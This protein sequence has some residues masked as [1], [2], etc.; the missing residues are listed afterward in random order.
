[1]SSKSDNANDRAIDENSSTS[2]NEAG[3]GKDM[4][5]PSI[6]DNNSC[7]ESTDDATSI[8]SEGLF[9][10]EVYYTPST[11]TPQALSPSDPWITESEL[12]SLVVA[13]GQESA[14][15]RELIGQV[16][17]EHEVHAY[18]HEET[19]DACNNNVYQLIWMKM[20][21]P[22]NQE[23]LSLST[24]IRYASK[25]NRGT[26]ILGIADIQPDVDLRLHGIDEVLVGPLSKTIVRQKYMKWT[27]VQT[28]HVDDPN[29][30]TPECPK[31][32][33]TPSSACSD[34]VTSNLNAS[35]DLNLSTSPEPRVTAQSSSGSEM[36]SNLPSVTTNA[37][38]TSKHGS[39]G[40]PSTVL[41]S[42]RNFNLQSVTYQPRPA[43]PTMASS[44]D[45]T[46]KEK[47]RRER[48]KDSCD[49]LRV[50][51]P[52]IRGRKTDMASI[53]EMTVDYLKIVNAAIPADFQNQVITLMSKGAVLPK[54]KTDG[55][56]GSARRS[57]RREP[58]P[59]ESPSTT[60]VSS[61]MD[62][63]GRSE[64]SNMASGSSM[65]DMGIPHSH[66]PMSTPTRATQAQMTMA[67]GK[68]ESTDSFKD[69][70]SGSKRMHISPLP[71]T[72]P[73]TTQSSQG[74]IYMQS[75]T[76]GRTDAND[77]N[78]DTSSPLHLQGVHIQSHI[79]GDLD[80]NANRMYPNTFL[81]PDY[82]I[83][84]P[85]GN[86]AAR[87]SNL[88]RDAYGMYVENA[89]YQYYGQPTSTA[90]Y[91][92]NSLSDYVNPNAV[93]PVGPQRY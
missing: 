65:F 4:R 89:F 2:T 30:L 50:L 93:L 91:N 12:K 9:L 68:R 25:S 8:C 15:L 77:P 64:G 17:L 37:T 46:T 43:R 3:D 84:T 34:T 59:P 69:I 42:L 32:P 54:I 31:T 45:H 36:S 6:L 90:S 39:P 67:G 14:R 5:I 72:S 10:E 81:S 70:K 33:T 88:E 47:L 74:L 56:R 71:M 57:G 87:M 40:T 26:I 75:D 79:Y 24:S 41:S 29:L 62:A 28:V 16:V 55:G 11:S 52:Y 86:A 23:T 63:S 76:D 51:L 48:I 49:Q 53:L 61:T 83:S 82:P 35:Q 18:R 20:T 80:T 7:H 66:S 92:A 78:R 73:T 22:A 1:M 27:S 85:V 60:R 21:V 13:D 38:P 44:A 58:D 19:F